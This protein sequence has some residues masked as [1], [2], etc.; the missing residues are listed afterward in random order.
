MQKAF[1]LDSSSLLLYYQVQYLCIN[2]PSDLPPDTLRRHF[3]LAERVILLNHTMHQ[4]NYK[5]RYITTLWVPRLVSTARWIGKD[6]EGSG[7]HLTNVLFQ[8]VLG[9][10][11]NDDSRDSIRARGVGTTPHQV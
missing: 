3:E 7:R 6:L 4:H 11:G 2:S 5:R 9:G 1:H 10:I 8:K